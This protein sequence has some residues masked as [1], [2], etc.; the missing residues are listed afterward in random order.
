MGADHMS[1][2]WTCG[3]V[4]ELSLIS[5]EVSYYSWQQSKWKN[6]QLHL[7]ALSFPLQ[8]QQVS[9]FLPSGH[10][11]LIH[12]NLMTCK[13]CCGYWIVE[14]QSE[15]KADGVIENPGRNRM[16]NSIPMISRPLI[17]CPLLK[18]WITFHNFTCIFNSWNM[19]FHADA[20]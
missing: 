14:K 4:W 7:T 15:R 19:H 20:M 5:Q 18:T 3:K 8:R 10:L 2:S 16:A 13:F 1:I 17:T 9:K 12:S 11:I 6:C